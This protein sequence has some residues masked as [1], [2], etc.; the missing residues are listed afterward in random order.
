M[1]PLRIGKLVRLTKNISA[2]KYG[3]DPIKKGEIMSFDG[4]L[5]QVRVI[6]ACSKDKQDQAD[7][8]K[9]W[10]YLREELVLI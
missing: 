6:T 7:K 4:D 1:K 10:P 9:T 2:I 8:Q 5:Y 3:F